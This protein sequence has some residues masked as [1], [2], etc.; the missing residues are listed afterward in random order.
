MVTQRHERRL[1]GAPPRPGERGRDALGS[2]GGLAALSLDALSSVAYGPEAIVLVLVAAG[3]GAIRYSLPV[4]AAIT[5]LLVVLVVSYGQVIAAHPE[6]GGAY[7]V[8]KADLGGAVSELAAASLVVD[9]VLTVAV[10]LAAGAGSLVST[11]PS[12]QGHELELC[13]AG[14]ALLTLVN[15]RGIAESA[16]FL[17]LPTAVF[18]AGIGVVIVG[19]LLRSH[20]AGA[21]GS[22]IPAHTG[23]AIGV[24]LLL[25]AFAAGCSALTGVEAIANAVPSFREPRVGNARR[26]ELMLGALL[27]VMLLGLGTLIVRFHIVPRGGV[28]VLA[29]LTAAALGTGPAF[30]VIGL[31]VTLVLL[32]AANTSFGGLPVLLSLLAQDNRMPHLFGLRAER[33]VFRYGLVSL[34][35]SAALLLWIVNG[36]TQRLVPLFAIGVFIGFTISQT[37]LVL[38]WFR[39]RPPG[40]WQRAAINAFGALL[41]A[42]ATVVF[43]LAK[44]LAGAWIVVVLIPLLIL[45]FKR[46]NVYYT[47]VSAEL[48]LGAI[49]P[50]PTPSR[51]LVIV[52][53]A[54][55]SKLSFEA[56]C[57]AKSLGD[58]VVAV[59]IQ[60]DAEASRKLSADWDEWNPGVRLVVLS[61]PERHLVGPIVDYVNSQATTSGR[62]VAVLIPEVEPRK[63]RHEILQN[64]RGALLALALRRRTD[65][66]ICTL[67][68]RL[69]D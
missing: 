19:G 45:L 57:A 34:S 2:L 60:F 21:I 27:G 23:A 69:H 3:T 54:G 42:T 13:L 37:G 20:R 24:I 16:R 43:L 67:P 15:L 52:P 5:V 30:H 11:Y 29:Q 38:H 58:E 53:V 22:V 48:E 9:Y 49:P 10:S 51:A 47:K 4:T 55:V 40:W 46:V 66:V 7:A 14:L 63:R 65:A 8:A 32:L 25:K 50:L 59:S 56:I 26:T 31:S 62:R 39:V 44:F 61:N 18:I 12:L 33:R 64:Q 17:M 41:T 68:F 28:T 35:A 6:G 1:R 36:N